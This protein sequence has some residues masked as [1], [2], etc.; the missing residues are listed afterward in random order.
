MAAFWA[1]CVTTA[2]VTT[3]ATTP[4]GGELYLPRVL[5]S[6]AVLARA[7]ARPLIWG[8][9]KPGSTVAVTMSGGKTS[10][11][12]WSGA[13]HV[14]VNGTWEVR[15]PATSATSGVTIVVSSISTKIVL[16]DIAFGDVFV[17][18]GQS[19]MA[20]AVIQAFNATAI[21]DEAG[22]PTN[23]TFPS[24]RLFTVKVASSAVPGVDVN[25][26]TPYVGWGVASNATV[27]GPRFQWFSAVC[28]LTGRDV[29]RALGGKVPIGLLASNVGGTHIASW[30]SSTALKQC[31][32]ATTMAAKT[33]TTLTQ[34]TTRLGRHSSGY[35]DVQDAIRDGGGGLYLAMIAPLLKYAV[36]QVLWYQGE[37]DLGDP[38]RYACQQRAM[39]LDWQNTWER[40]D[41]KT[42]G[43]QSS[44]V[45]KTASDALGVPPLRFTFVELAPGPGE[46]QA[47]H[48]TYLTSYLRTSQLETLNMSGVAYASAVDEGDPF[49]RDGWWHPRAKQ[50]V[51]RRLA[52]VVLR[53]TY[54]VKG[55]ASGP[56]LSSVTEKTTLS[57]TTQASAAGYDL[58]FEPSA[59]NG[60]VL[61][62]TRNCST[63]GTLL[64]TSYDDAT[65][66]TAF[67]KCAPGELCAACCSDAGAAFELRESATGAWINAH[68]AIDAASSTLSITAAKGAGAR[69]TSFSGIRYAWTD[70]PLCVLRNME[71][72]VASPFQKAGCEFDQSTHFTLWPML[73]NVK[74]DVPTA[75][76]SSGSFVFLGH[77][78]DALACAQKAAAAGGGGGGGATNASKQL[79]SFT[80]YGAGNAERNS[81][82][83]RGCYGR[84][85]GVWAPT[86]MC[87]NGS[88]G[89]AG[90]DV[91]SGQLTVCK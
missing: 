53:D 35:D 90:H 78:D 77:F 42:S 23:P 64:N 36:Q 83:A 55:I 19:N 37:A 8:W 79:D 25:T 56:T 38:L 66:Q 88:P 68:A 65:L 71:G 40:G 34:R 61:V 73:D 54:G 44:A 11:M 62:P 75:N 18:G 41:G 87:P 15:L 81:S 22:T 84:N 13:A 30:S 29:W 27:G 63:V 76:A 5:S 70:Y 58:H 21:I 72:F 85:D 59:A 2:A 67:A 32:A 82:F 74:G 14:A 39:I 10:T 57:T 12:G 6:H 43:S 20:Y 52:A 24:L 60:L 31:V 33:K 50:Q 46:Q 4:G 28:Y 45:A 51:G 7:P 89:C 47:K 9:A 48:R 16:S 17:C 49:S 69:A 86:N 91:A 80:Y 26:S 3:S 1:L